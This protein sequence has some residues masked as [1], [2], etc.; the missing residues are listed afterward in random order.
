MNYKMSIISV[1]ECVDVLKNKKPV[2]IFDDDN[3][4]EGDVCFISEE[5]TE[6][7]LIFLMNECKG[8]ICTTLSYNDVERLSLPVLNKKGENQTGSTNFIIPLDHKKSSTGI[9][10]KDRLMVIK[11][12]IDCENTDN[13][14][15][16]GHQNFLRV[17]KEGIYDRQGHTESCHSMANLAGYKSATICELVDNSGVPRGYK[18]VCEFAKKYDIPITLIS[19]IKKHYST[20]SCVPSINCSEHEPQDLSGKTFIVTGSSSGMGKAVKIK[21]REQGATVI[22]ISRTEGIDLLDLYNIKRMIRELNQIDGIIHCAGFLE[23]GPIVETLDSF[24]KHV[25]VNVWG[26]LNLLKES[27]EKLTDGATVI[28]ISSNAIYSEEKKKWWG[29]YVTTKTMLSNILGFL[30]KENK[31]VKFFEVSPSKTYTKML[32]SVYPDIEKSKCI[33]T[34]SVG[35]VVYKLI[36]NKQLNDSGTTFHI[37]LKQS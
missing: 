25:D 20:I 18:S 12:V 7:D 31:N 32:R 22:A 19:D 3:E 36:A 30:A 35:E 23:V 14:V 21:L 17:S 4:Q 37:K 16:P 26:F 28:C 33:T 9:S 6:N 5:L 10:A 1:N 24:Y 27:N 11:D 13:L 15:W 34:Y 2:I 8:V 29:M